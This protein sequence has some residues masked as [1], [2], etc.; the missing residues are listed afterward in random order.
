MSLEGALYS[1]ITGDAAVA[2]LVSTRVYP[3]EIPERSTYPSVSY[4][5]V[6]GRSVQ[7][8]QLPKSGTAA[9]TSIQIN[10]FAET[11]RAAQQLLAA[12]RAAI[13]AVRWTADGTSIYSC[14]VVDEF[15][16]DRESG[17]RI[18][19]VAQMYDIMHS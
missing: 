2:A 19:G 3:V 8:H 4:Q 14:W 10:A 5:R 13:E 15:D 11:R 1:Q 16:I 18:E 9:F 17:A 7:S 12:V 6:G